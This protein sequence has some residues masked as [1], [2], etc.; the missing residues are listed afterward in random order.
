MGTRGDF[1][2]KLREQRQ[3]VPHVR[4][5]G[6]RDS[7]RLSPQNLRAQT[8]PRDRDRDPRRLSVRVNRGRCPVAAPPR[9]PPRAPPRSGH[10]TSRCAVA[11]WCRSRP[12]GRTPRGPGLS[13]PEPAPRSPLKAG[14][15]PAHLVQRGLS[16]LKQRQGLSW[17]EGQRLTLEPVPW[18]CPC[19]SRGGGGCPLCQL[20]GLGP[21]P[22]P[23][24]ASAHPSVL[25]PSSSC[26]DH[27]PARLRGPVTVGR[28]LAGASAPPGG[29]SPAGPGALTWRLYTFHRA[30]RVR[31]AACLRCSEQAQGWDGL[32]SLVPGSGS[33]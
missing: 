16:L 8:E 3:G 11:G 28:Q 22:A 15:K 29:C 25:S 31:A 12:P 5:H 13:C 24:M 33:C 21:A 20:P 23:A 30:C 26:T 10:T 27:R 4:P 18:S 7:Q 2:G 17:R 32:S 14:P 9:H 19:Q 6:H 1:G